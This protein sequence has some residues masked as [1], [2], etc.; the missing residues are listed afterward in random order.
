MLLVDI[1]QLDI[2]LAQSIGTSG[3][4]DEVDDIWRVFRLQ[5]EDVGRLGGAQNFCE[6]GQV[7]TECNVSITSE[8]RE[9]FGLEVHRD[10][11]D[12][13]VVHCL[14]GDT[15][16]IAVEVAVL[17]E[18]FDRVDDLVEANQRLLG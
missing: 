8:G 12:V 16:V 14:E 7:D 1:H 15:R 5:C 2:V 3:L 4:E 9:G 6:G 10:E 18:I 17:D 11:G 13:T